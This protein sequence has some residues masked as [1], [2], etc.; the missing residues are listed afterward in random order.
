MMIIQTKRYLQSVSLSF[1]IIDNFGFI[2]LK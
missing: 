2:T 1:N